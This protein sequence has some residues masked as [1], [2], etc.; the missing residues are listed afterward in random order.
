VEERAKARRLKE[1]VRALSHR[2]YRIYFLCMLVSFTGTWM[3][4]VAQSWLVYRLTDSALLLG[5]V[6][7]L[8]QLPVFLFSPLGGVMADRHNRHRIIIITQVLSMVQALVLAWLT[9]RGQVTIGWVIWLALMLGFINAFDFSARQSFVSELVSKQDL[10]NAIALNSSMINGARI[11]GPAIAGV[12]VAGL[13]EGLCFLINGLSFMV[14]IVGLFSIRTIRRLDHRSGRSALS[15]LKEGFDFIRKARPVQALLILVALV[16]F[17][18]LPYVV[19]MPIFAGR[20]LGGGAQALG[21]MMSA[22][23]AGALLGALSL[24]ARRNERG[25]GRVIALSVMAVGALLVL[26][27][28]S[29]NLML[30]TAL[31]VP[32]GFA[33]MVQLSGSNTLLQT[34]IDDRLRGRVMSFYSMSLMSTVIGNLYAGATAARIGAPMTVAIGGL[35][36]FAGALIFLWRLPE[37]KSEDVHMLVS[38]SGIDGD[39]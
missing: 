12:M 17:F 33:V 8:G 22:A 28:F 3:Q 39:A 24:A 6:G 36:C 26:F 35:I 9:L 18:G 23:G 29:R 7:F 1:T 11:V 20:V 15:D 4:N 2:N 37:L 31:L 10:M 32:I 14:I 25:L 27:S 13:G 16:S 19:L 30:S 34:M 21:I 38:E 5:L